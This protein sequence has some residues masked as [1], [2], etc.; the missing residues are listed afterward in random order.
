[1]RQASLGRTFG[2]GALAALAL[3]MCG[4]ATATASLYPLTGLPEIG[5]CVSD[6]GHGAFRGLRNHCIVTSPTNTGNWEWEPGPA[7]PGTTIKE[8]LQG[9]VF[10]TTGGGRISCHTAFLTGEV[11]S[12]KTVKFSNLTI[13]GC[14]DVGPNLP[15]Y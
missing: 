7:G 12:G 13:Q 9:P 1:M 10:E 8:T 2:I 11:T 3:A 4:T 15:C 6:P 14:L 5:R